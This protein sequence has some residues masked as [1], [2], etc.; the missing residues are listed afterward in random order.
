MPP[1]KIITRG[2]KLRHDFAGP[3][4]SLLTRMIDY[5]LPRCE[6]DD[7]LCIEMERHVEERKGTVINMRVFRK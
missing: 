5:D 7:G 4:A 1:S 2:T 3:K 6:W